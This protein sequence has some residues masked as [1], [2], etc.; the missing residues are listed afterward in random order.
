MLLHCL[1]G[2]D[3]NFLTGARPATQAVSHAHR[4]GGGGRLLVYRLCLRDTVEERL[5]A[6]SAERKRSLSAL[7][8][9]AAGRSSSEVRLSRARKLARGSIAPQL[10]PR[11]LS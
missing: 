9:P 6:L 10:T 11:R 1:S 3:A 5:L 7:I 4:L 2:E 8:R